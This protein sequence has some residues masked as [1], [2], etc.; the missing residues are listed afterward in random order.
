MEAVRVFTEHARGSDIRIGELQGAKMIN[1][2][3]EM[4]LTAYGYPVA[5]GTQVDPRIHFRVFDAV[6][7]VGLTANK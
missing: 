2:V 5:D 3:R 4:Q 1:G 7:S 6:H